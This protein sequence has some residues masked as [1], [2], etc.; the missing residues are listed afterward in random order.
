MNL[1]KPECHYGY[2]AA[3]VDAILAFGPRQQAF[4]AFMRG[5]TMTIC[6]ASPEREWVPSA[7]GVGGRML[8]DVGPP[9]CDLPHGTVVYLWDFQRFIEGRLIVD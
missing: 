5:Q 9:L 7:D 2:P 3:Q 1:P 6:D 4:W 8:V